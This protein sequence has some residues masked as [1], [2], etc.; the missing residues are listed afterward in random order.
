MS[1]ALSACFIKQFDPKDDIQHRLSTIIAHVVQHHYH[2][3]HA[4]CRSQTQKWE[5]FAA[6][7]QHLQLV[8]A[9]LQPGMV[10][11]QASSQSA[12]P[13]GLSVMLDML[14]EFSP[15]PDDA[16]HCPSKQT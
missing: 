3:L 10:Q 15:D 13:P 11:A 5:L 9:A 4:L 6:C 16:C 7:L 14:R 8:T 12:P 1:R 2:A